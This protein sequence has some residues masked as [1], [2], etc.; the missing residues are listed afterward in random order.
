LAPAIVPPLVS[1]ILPPLVSTPEALSSLSP[2]VNAWTDPPPNLH[3]VGNLP[4]SVSTPLII[5]WLDAISSQSGVWSQ[6]RVGMTLTFQV[7]LKWIKF[8]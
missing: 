8:M 5:R 7:R 3:L 1:A 2:G 4:F 6:G